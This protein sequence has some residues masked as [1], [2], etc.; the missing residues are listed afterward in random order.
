MIGFEGD[1]VWDTSKPDGQP[2]RCLETSRAVEF[3]GFRAEMDFD[4][5][6]Q[7]TIDWYEQQSV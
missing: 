5:G 1:I 2:R 3:F 7:R 4:E 6:L